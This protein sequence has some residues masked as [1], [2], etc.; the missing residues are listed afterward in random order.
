MICRLQPIQAWGAG[1]E[2]GGQHH[3]HHG[4]AGDQGARRNKVRICDLSDHG[5]S[6][7]GGDGEVRGLFVYFRSFRQQF[8]QKIVY[9]SGILTCIIGV[10]GE[11]ADHLTTTTVHGCINYNILWP[12]GVWSHKE[13]FWR[14]I[15][16]T[17]IGWSKFSNQS[18]RHSL[19]TGF[20]G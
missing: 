8:L 17:L 4:Q 13:N 18:E 10:E 20:M 15:T 6:R 11:Y 7:D 3:H 9:L 19:I 12:S 14:K 2:G 16:G 5:G 1:R